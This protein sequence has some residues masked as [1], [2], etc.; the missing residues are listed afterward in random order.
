[1]ATLSGGDWVD[2]FP[3]SK[4]VADLTKPFR[5][6]VTNFLAALDKAGATV[7]IASTLRPAEAAY[8]MSY[9]FRIAKT[10]LDPSAVPAMNGVDIDWVHRDAKGN[11]D[12]NASKNAANDMVSG[13]HIVYAPALK[14]RHTEGNAIDMNISWAG[15]LTI[16]TAD[17]KSCTIT[18][19][20][21]TGSNVELG[22]VGA[23]YGVCKL[24][25]DPPHWSSDGH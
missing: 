18:S 21:R 16:S 13:F 15:D 22:G 2:K 5:D 12:L 10:G 8:L 23:G 11:P 3:D 24:A 1:M 9:S 14:S 25:T 4:D 6:N 19:V 20:P 17:G 7:H